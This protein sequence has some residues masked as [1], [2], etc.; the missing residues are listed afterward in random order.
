MLS[1]KD[2]EAGYNDG[3][4]RRVYGSSFQPGW[5]TPRHRYDSYRAGYT[6]GRGD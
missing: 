2:W 6:A 3:K 1:D 4:S 5:L